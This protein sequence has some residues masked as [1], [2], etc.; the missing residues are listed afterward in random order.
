MLHSYSN[1]LAILNVIAQCFRAIT[2]F[3]KNMKNKDRQRKINKG[4]Q[5]KRLETVMSKNMS[6][7][8]K[9][10]MHITPSEEELT[11]ARN[12]LIKEAQK[13][14]YP[15]EYKALKQNKPISEKSSLIKLNPKL[16]EG[17]IIMKGRLDNLQTMPEQLKNPII[18]PKD[19][20]ITDLIILQ[21][22]QMIAHSGPELTLR[23]IRLQYWIPGG[24][25]Q[26]RSAIKLCGHNL[27]KHPYPQGHTQQI[28][29]LP[30]PRI[31]PE[32]LKQ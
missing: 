20:R 19:S 13:S 6:P 14:S 30:I 25:R 10:E 7:G 23:N 28:A 27:C 15:E 16:R 32:I 11:F 26:I 1:Y 22:H 31:T 21:H 12:Y 17:L 8:D 24:K 29:N 18:L 5:I 3:S 4:F 9:K 2:L